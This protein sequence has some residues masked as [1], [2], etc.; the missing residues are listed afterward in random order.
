MAQKTS[1]RW[2]QIEAYPCEPT[3]A[4]LVAKCKAYFLIGNFVDI[5]VES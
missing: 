5:G 3:G 4:K 2:S 1:Q